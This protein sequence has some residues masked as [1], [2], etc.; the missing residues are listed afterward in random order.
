MAGPGSI[1]MLNLQIIGEVV[2]EDY[3]YETIP[4]KPIITGKKIWR[5]PEVPS[6]KRNSLRNDYLRD[7]WTFFKAGVAVR[8]LVT[9]D[10][11]RDNHH[12]LPPVQTQTSAH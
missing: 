4:K 8:A 10:H 1:T 11:G 7:L 6:R 12:W 9:V 3:A 2:L 5:R